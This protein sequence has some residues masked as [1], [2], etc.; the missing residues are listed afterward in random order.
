MH[1]MGI[2]CSVLDAVH[3]ELRRY[4]GQRALRVG[5]RIGEF[6]G[7][8]GESLRFCFEAIVKRSEPA[9]LSLEIEWCRP[10]D[11]RRGDELEIAYLE[12]EEAGPLAEV[13]T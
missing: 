6:A 2:A 13:A 8:D 12:L 3:Q 7:V 10:E 9:P 4:P 11:G 1:E 5:L